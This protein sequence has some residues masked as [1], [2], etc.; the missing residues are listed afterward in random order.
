MGCHSAVYFARCVTVGDVFS[1]LLKLVFQVRIGWDIPLNA[2]VVSFVITCLL[3]LINLGSAVAFNAI[4]SLTVGAILS[5]YLISITCVA[6]R[7][8]RKD[9]PLPYARWSLGKA[10]LPINIAAVMFL[11]VVYIFT[12]FPIINHPTLYVLAPVFTLDVLILRNKGLYELELTD[13]WHD[14]DIRNRVL[15]SPR[16]QTL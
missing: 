9:R 13:L 2:L 3:S 12:F 7:K 16:A 8:I 4:V 14:G 15:L 6:L 5:S 10:G 1:A 11:A